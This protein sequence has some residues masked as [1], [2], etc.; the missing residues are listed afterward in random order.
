MHGDVSWLR[1]T[2]DPAS[3]V[4][5]NQAKFSSRR[6][7]WLMQNR[8]RRGTRLSVAQVTGIPESGVSRESLR[9]AMNPYGKVLYVEFS[10]GNNEAWLR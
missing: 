7:P 2:K 3:Q 8:C 1:F 5:N 4:K 9:E 6:H 10:F